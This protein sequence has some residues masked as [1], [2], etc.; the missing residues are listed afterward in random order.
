M[1]ITNGTGIKTRLKLGVGMNHWEWDEKSF[2]L[3]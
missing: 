1:G 3:I 2:L